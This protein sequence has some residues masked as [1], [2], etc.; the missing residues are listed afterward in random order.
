LHDHYN[1]PPQVID[2]KSKSYAGPGVVW[3]ADDSIDS[4]W[5]YVLL[6]N[7][8]AAGTPAATVAVDC[9]ELE[10]TPL[11]T[12]ALT[13]MWKGGSLPTATQTL[14]VVLAPHASLFVKLSACV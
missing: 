1:H 11:T 14:S 9:A 7:L 4:G 5:K 6:V 2:A 13:E 8:V 10:L 12:C 3:R